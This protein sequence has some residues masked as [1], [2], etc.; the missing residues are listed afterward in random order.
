MT[1]VCTEY[2]RAC[3]VHFMRVQNIMS[4]VY[5][6][7]VYEGSSL[8]TDCLYLLSSVVERGFG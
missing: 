1:K 3:H 5:L 8:S 7:W 4:R 2:M 6:T